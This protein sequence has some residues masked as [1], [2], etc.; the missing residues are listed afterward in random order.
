MKSQIIKII[1]ILFFSCFIFLFTRCE[2]VDVPKDTPKC[3]KSKIKK[4][5]DNC[6]GE[7]FEYDY[8]GKTVYY[9]K[10]T[11]CIDGLNYLY[12]DNCNLICSPDGGL[13]G[14]GDGGCD[15]F[16]VAATNQRLIWKK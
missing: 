11:S 15:D 12:D 9:F 13:D 4:E 7:V 10:S 8:K 6:L 1:S 16:F 2:K 3:I 5:N 14:R